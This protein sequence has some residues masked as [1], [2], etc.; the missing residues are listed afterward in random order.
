MHVAIFRGNVE[1]ARQCELRIGGQFFAKP[2]AQRVEPGQ[3][4][5]V[6]VAVDGLPV[7]NVGADKT[8]ARHGRGDQAFLRIGEMRVAADHIGQRFARQQRNTVVGFLPGEGDLVTGCLDFRMRKIV[9]FEFRFLQANKVG[10]AGFKPFEQ[11]RQA[12]LQ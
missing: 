6:F 10:F 8:H 7:R 1:I 5:S 12:D 2:R 11:L 9:I 4:V 3:L